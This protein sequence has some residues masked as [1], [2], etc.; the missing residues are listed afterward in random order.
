MMRVDHEKTASKG[1][2]LI[3]MARI[4][5]SQNQINLFKQKIADTERDK[6]KLTLMHS[7]SKS[8]E[9]T[10]SFL[11]YINSLNSAPVIERFRDSEYLLEAFTQAEDEG[12]LMREGGFQDPEELQ[13]RYNLWK[14]E[15]LPDV[16]F[17]HNS[18]PDFTPIEY[19][20]VLKDEAPFDSQ[21]E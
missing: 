8:T 2:Q 4:L 9:N 16:P 6:N 11:E 13:S 7:N 17:L 1:L 21:E 5:E 10:T 3:K 14:L 18:P 15:N 12:I 20:G 19:I